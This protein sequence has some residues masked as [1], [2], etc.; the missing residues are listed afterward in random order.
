MSKISLQIF[1]KNTFMEIQPP[2]R[3]LGIDPG[4]AIVGWA[5]LEVTQKTNAPQ[6]V[7]YGH[8]TTD[9]YSSD[10][11]RLEEI[12]QDLNKIIKQHKPHVAAIESLFFFKNQKTIITVAQARGVILYICKSAKLEISSYTPL[13]IKQSLTGYGRANKKQIQAM[14]TKTLSMQC[15]T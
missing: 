8:I 11:E 2:L 1:P 12:A 13:Q 4:T 6:P 9:T 5:I 10:Q 14:I 7:A 15:T 3:I